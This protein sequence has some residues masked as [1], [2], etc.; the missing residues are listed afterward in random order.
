MKRLN[1]KGLTLIELIVSIVLI[2]VVMLF[3][4]R[5]LA[6]VSYDSDNEFFASKN[7]EQ[8]IEIIDYIETIIRKADITA[9]PTVS[10]PTDHVTIQFTQAS[11][12]KTYSI[13]VY[14]DNIQIVESPSK[15]LRVWDIETGVFSYTN[16]TCKRATTVSDSTDVY[17]PW[18]CVIPVYT[19]NDDNNANNNNTLDDITLAFLAR[20]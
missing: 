9:G 12:S 4:Y 7:Q 17:H 20:N 1:N 16:V 11:L 19:V 8:R 6:N 10:T 15:T 14:A 2:S 13:L 18:E 3:L 5:L